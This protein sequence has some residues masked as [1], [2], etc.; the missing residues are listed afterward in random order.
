MPEDNITNGGLFLKSTIEKYCS[1]VF[2]NP[3]IYLLCWK[4]DFKQ[5][6]ERNIFST[7]ESTQ[8]KKFNMRHA[9]K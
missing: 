2:L 1:Q 7:E 5:L 9:R 8:I 4:R 6:C 3:L